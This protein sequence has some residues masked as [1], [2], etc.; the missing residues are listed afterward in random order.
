VN[1]TAYTLILTQGVHVVR[2]DVADAIRAAIDNGER[3]VE[4]DVDL[5][6]GPNSSRRTLIVTAHVVAL[7]E[8]KLPTRET[9]AASGGKIRLIR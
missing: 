8:A 4:V 9:A 1:A 5:F 3:T 2:G 7:V 6:G